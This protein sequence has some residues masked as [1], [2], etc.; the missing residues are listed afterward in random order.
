VR[1]LLQLLLLLVCSAVTAAVLLAASPMVVPREKA[2][3]DLSLENEL[4]QVL[5]KQVSPAEITA[6]SINQALAAR[7]P[8]PPLQSLSCSLQEEVCSLYLT[9]IVKEQLLHARVDLAVQ[10]DGSTFHV[11]VLRG[12]YGQLSVPRGL[13]MPLRPLL[14]QLAA[15]YAPEL[16][17]LFAIPRLKFVPGKLVLDPRF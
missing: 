13:L 17:A 11:T 5:I 8:P 1:F 15:H 14:D 7:L 2:V 16:K 9:F 12:A 3:A 4:E 6:Q 10:R